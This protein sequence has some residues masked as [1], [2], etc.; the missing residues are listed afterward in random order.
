MIFKS[1]FFTMILFVFTGAFAEVGAD[2]E[3]SSSSDHAVIEDQYFAGLSL[4]EPV[5]PTRKYERNVA[6]LHGDDSSPDS[7]WQGQLSVV[8]EIPY[9]YPW[10]SHSTMSLR[11]LNEIEERERNKKESAQ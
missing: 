8:K 1:V 2:R 10:L 4:E 11:A 9:S 5:F 6:R 7:E 3:V